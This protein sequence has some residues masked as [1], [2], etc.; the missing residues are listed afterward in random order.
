MD[1]AYACNDFQV[2]LG[3]LQVFKLFWTYVASVSSGC[4]KNRSGVA[5]VAMRV[6]S[7]GGTNGPRVGARNTS[8]GRTGAGAS[9]RVECRHAHRKQG[10][11]RASSGR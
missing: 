3:V 8:T 10:T 4:C 9:T 1:A 11:T 7:G 5:H 2:F 6:R